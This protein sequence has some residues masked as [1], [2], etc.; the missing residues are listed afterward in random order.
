[1]TELLSNYVSGQW[2]SGKGAGTALHDP[3][4]G[5]ELVRDEALASP[6]T[7]AGRR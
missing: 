1:M 2:Q 5:T 4:L 6:K 7:T 3:V